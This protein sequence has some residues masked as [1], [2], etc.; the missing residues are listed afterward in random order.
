MTEISENCITCSEETSYGRKQRKTGFEC[1]A[2]HR[3]RYCDVPESGWGQLT[4]NPRGHETAEYAFVHPDADRAMMNAWCNAGVA[5]GYHLDAAS[6]KRV[7]QPEET[8][9]T[10]IIHADGTWEPL[11]DWQAERQ[12]LIEQGSLREATMTE[13]KEDARWWFVGVDDPETAILGV[14]VHPALRRQTAEGLIRD[15]GLMSVTPW[16][17]TDLQP[18]EHRAV[19]TRMC[20]FKVIDERGTG[21]SLRTWLNQQAEDAFVAAMAEP[22]DRI[23][24]Q[25]GEKVKSGFIRD[26]VDGPSRYRRAGFQLPEN[27][28]LVERSE[29]KMRTSWDDTRSRSQLIEENARLAARVSDLE[30]RN[31]AL[32]EGIPK[33]NSE[34]L[35][36]L[37]TPNIM[38]SEHFAMGP[39]GR[40]QRMARDI[41]QP[42]AVAQAKGIPRKTRCEPGVQDM[43]GDDVCADADGALAYLKG[44]W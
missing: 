30:I 3:K 18:G 20:Q 16:G 43:T 29:P 38:T 23:A 37:P 21:M 15:W 33:L 25:I 27:R 32:A 36:E 4:R 7:V 2:C 6:S 22:A 34:Y 9:R 28:F 10:D 11:A 26:S 13:T 24:A 1:A 12:R 14:Y 42:S 41:G 35:S 44:R 40:W 19:S 17:R 31:K 8:W 39:D 5:K